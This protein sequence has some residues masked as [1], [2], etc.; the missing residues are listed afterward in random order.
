MW[1]V[2]CVS[3]WVCGVRS[4]WGEEWGAGVS[5]LRV[6]GWADGGA[7]V[8]MVVHGAGGLVVVVATLFH[9]PRPSLR[10]FS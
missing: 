9:L 3:E 5:C 10:K 4:V 1:G 6:C 8:L 7:V 2:V